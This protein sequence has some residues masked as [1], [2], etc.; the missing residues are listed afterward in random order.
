M[1]VISVLGKLRKENGAFQVNLGYKG[2]SKL[3]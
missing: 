1:P 2:S 3:A